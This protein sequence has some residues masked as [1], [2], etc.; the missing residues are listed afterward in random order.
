[1]GFTIV[2]ALRVLEILLS[3]PHH[4]PLSVILEVLSTLQFGLSTYY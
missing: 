2:D 1:M 4:M 3:V